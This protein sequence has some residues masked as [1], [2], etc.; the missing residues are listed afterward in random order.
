[1]DTSDIFN[2]FTGG[3]QGADQ[4]QV[5]M[6]DESGE[7]VEIDLQELMQELNELPEMELTDLF[8]TL[9]GLF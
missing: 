8:E 5:G 4:I 2:M 9:G 7:F 1:M 6:I 3:G